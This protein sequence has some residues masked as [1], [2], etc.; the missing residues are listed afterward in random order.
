MRAYCEGDAFWRSAQTAIA[1]GCDA[2]GVFLGVAD[3]FLGSSFSLGEVHSF[4]DRDFSKDLEFSLL[5]LDS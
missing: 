5:L 2:D 1:V 4:E 3:C